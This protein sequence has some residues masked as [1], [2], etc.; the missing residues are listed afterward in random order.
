[1]GCAAQLVTAGSLKTSLSPLIDW[2]SSASNRAAIPFANLSALAKHL[3]NLLRLALANRLP[4]GHDDSLLDS[5]WAR[6]IESARRAL[7]SQTAARQG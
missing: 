1:M 2:M 5:G 6:R 3:I 7:P 4:A